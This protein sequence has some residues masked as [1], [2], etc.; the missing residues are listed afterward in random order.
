MKKDKKKGAAVATPAPDATPAPTT[1]WWD[2]GTYT[3]TFE[4]VGGTTKIHRAPAFCFVVFFC[5]LFLSSRFAHVPPIHNIA[6]FEC[7]EVYHTDLYPCSPSRHNACLRAFLKMLLATDGQ[8]R[9]L[10]HPLT[11]PTKRTADSICLALSLLLFA[12]YFKQRIASFGLQTLL[13]LMTV[14]SAAAAISYITDCDETFNYWEPM[15]Y[16]IH[17][18]GLQTWE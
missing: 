16:M 18:F 10:A 3:F 13:I 11:R 17:G 4:Q 7:Q 2:V 1:V 14:R 15:H 6:T 9:K 8:G 5:S 12:P